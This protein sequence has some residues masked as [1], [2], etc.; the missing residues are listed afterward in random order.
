MIVQVVTA[1]LVSGASPAAPAVQP[2]ASAA[3]KPEMVCERQRLT[4]SNVR[5]T[6]CVEKRERELTREEA[7]RLVQREQERA[8][9]RGADK[10]TR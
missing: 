7:Q 6:V 4:G 3:P 5:Q 10:M 2:Q 1:L 9:S 8:V